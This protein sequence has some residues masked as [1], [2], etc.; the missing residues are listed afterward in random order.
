[1]ICLGFDIVDMRIRVLEGPLGF[2]GID[3]GSVVLESEGVVDV[4]DVED[5]ADVLLDDFEDLLQD[6][7]IGL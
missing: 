5:T 2:L 6:G 1:M 3:A 7:E 4:V